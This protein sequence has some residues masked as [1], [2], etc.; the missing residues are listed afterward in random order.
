[1]NGNRS[2]VSAEPFHQIRRT[3]KTGDTV[4]IELPMNVRVTNWYRNSAAFERGPLVFSLGLHAQV[5]RKY[6][7]T[8]SDPVRRRE[9]THHRVPVSPKSLRLRIASPLN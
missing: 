7:G 8:D 2:E 3:W 1:M 5:L 9:T 6:S 4:E